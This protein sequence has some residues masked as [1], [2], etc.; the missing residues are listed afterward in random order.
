MVRQIRERRRTRETLIR[1][2][3][4]RVQGVITQLHGD[5]CRN[6]DALGERQQA[7]GRLEERAE[8]AREKLQV[9]LTAHQKW[10]SYPA[11]FLT[12]IRENEKQKRAE[13]AEQERL[14]EQAARF[15]LKTLQRQV[16]QLPR[17][18][19]GDRSA[20]AQWDWT[21]AAV[22]RKAGVSQAD[23]DSAF[24]ILNPTLLRLVVG[25]T[26]RIKDPGSVAKRIQDIAMR[27]IKNVY[28]DDTV[29]ADVSNVSGPDT[30]SV[31]DPADLE[32]EIEV[33]QEDLRQHE[34]RLATA[35]DQ[36]KALALLNALRDEHAGFV[37]TLRDYNEYARVWSCRTDI[38]KEF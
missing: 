28:S 31:S 8:K 13:I 35:K 3:G 37:T 1:A 23:L 22:L 2:E 34:A 4:E 26:M 5:Q 25:D 12:Q 19:H 24:H 30:E 17:Q 18:I 32:R 33:K 36:E 10:S 15:D 7:K 14:L 9:V 29:E 6:Q 16:G 38:Q 27:V 11:D 21:A 20:L